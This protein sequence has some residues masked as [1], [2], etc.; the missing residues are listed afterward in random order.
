MSCKQGRSIDIISPVKTDTSMMAK[1]C[2]VYKHMMTQFQCTTDQE[3]SFKQPV[4]VS[5]L[6]L[7]HPDHRSLKGLKK[8]D[9]WTELVTEEGSWMTP[10]SYWETSAAC[11][12]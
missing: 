7:C 6:V 11:L 1:N 3:R 12:I 5:V 10:L 4:H 2:I 8:G 9:N